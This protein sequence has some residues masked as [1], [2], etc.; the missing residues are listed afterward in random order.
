VSKPDQ[1]GHAGLVAAYREGLGLAAVAVISGSS[2]IHIAAQSAEDCALAAAETVDQRWWC[3]RAAD[4]ER[5]ATAA[6]ARMRRCE[7]QAAT[8]SLQDESSETLASA[9]YAIVRAAKRLNIALQTEQEMI[10]EA[11]A[12]IARIDGEIERMQQRGELKS[13]NKSY[14]A[15]RI[16]ASARGERVVRYADWMRDYKAGLVRKLAATLRYL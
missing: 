14:Q 1:G 10:D 16:D 4:A 5:I 9:C 2:G 7:A 3:R 8:E 6:A 11:A 15:Y 12:V 13:V